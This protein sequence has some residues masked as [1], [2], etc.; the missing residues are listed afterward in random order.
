MTRRR[1]GQPTRRDLLTWAAAAPLL[2]LVARPAAA[3]AA[4]AREARLGA[5]LWLDLLSSAKPSSLRI[6]H[7]RRRCVTAAGRAVDVAVNEYC[8]DHDAATGAPLG[9]AVG[10]HGGVATAISVDMPPLRDAATVFCQARTADG[11]LVKRAYVW[12]PSGYAIVENGEIIE[13]GGQ[14]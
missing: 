4:R 3:W 9:L 10:S 13:R 2:R 11:R 6:A 12:S 1:L 14:L 7:P 5:A 8:I